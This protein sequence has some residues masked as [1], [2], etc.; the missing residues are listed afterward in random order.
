MDKKKH[1]R[2]GKLVIKDMKRFCISI[3]VLIG[4]I[5]LIC[6]IVSSIANSSNKDDIDNL[7]SVNA[8]KYSNEIV[9]KYESN[10]MKTLFINDYS[11]I[12][13]AIGMYIMNN[14]TLDKN[15]FSSIISKLQKVLNSQDWSS[16]N[17]NKPSMWNG[18]WQVNSD[19]I[20]KFK[21]S[22]KDIE[23]SWINDDDISSKIIFN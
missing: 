19:G 1:F 22:I 21:F 3:G 4:I 11:N 7:A 6:I 23:P 14:S 8:K 12:Q 18:K 9:S 5:V 20:L 16:L 13:N 15:S 17:I 10:E 2:I